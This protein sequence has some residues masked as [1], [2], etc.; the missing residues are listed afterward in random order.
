MI[1]DITESINGA[2]PIIIVLIQY[3]EIQYSLLTHKRKI[4]TISSKQPVRYPLE[5]LCVPYKKI[6]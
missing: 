2:F 1:H 4:P 5:S 6:N 3:G